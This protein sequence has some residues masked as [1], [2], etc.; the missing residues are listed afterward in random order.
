MIDLFQALNEEESSLLVDAIPLVTVLIA[1]ADGKID[2]KEK[3]WGAKMTKIRSYSHPDSLNDLYK[4][5]EENYAEKLE[6]LIDDLPTD[7]DQR[8]AAISEQ[9][10]GLNA[11]FA[12]LDPTVAYKLYMSLTSFA[13]HVA[14]SSGGFLRIGAIGPEEKKLIGLPMLTPIE[15]P[16]DE[17]V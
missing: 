5:A 7:V 3:S 17:E 14:K 9:L 2:Q 10:S 8:T 13:E 12:K 4:R 16:E 1:G 6:T 11:L 15:N